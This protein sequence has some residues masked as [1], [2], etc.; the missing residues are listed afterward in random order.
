MS[1]LYVLT[2]SSASGKTTLLRRVVAERMPRLNVIHVDD[3]RAARTATSWVERAVSATPTV[4]LLVAEGQERPHLILHA[5]K[6][7]GIT[8]RIVL[9]DCD[10]PERRRRLVELR[11]QPELDQP[12]MYRWAAYLRGQADALGLEIIDTTSQPVDDC[13]E[14]LADS[15]ER[16]WA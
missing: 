15:I 13:V 2:G 11:K 10:H 1:R 4:P 3:P 16:F 9:I 5:A 8:A 12:D 14:R 7:A 6:A